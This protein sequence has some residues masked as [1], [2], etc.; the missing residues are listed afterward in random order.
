MERIRNS[1]EAW[2]FHIQ[3][4]GALREIC[5]KRKKSE[6]AK[7]NSDVRWTRNL[8]RWRVKDSF[9]KNYLSKE[10]TTPRRIREVLI[11]LCLEHKVVTRDDIKRELVQKG[12]ATDEGQVGRIL[13]TISREI[14]I[15]KRIYLRQ[16]I[17]YD[18]QNWEKEN[19]RVE[20][21]YRSMI[22]EWLDTLG[23]RA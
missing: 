10:R 20:E 17:C 1:S 21:R 6:K 5:W 23:G 2:Y 16:I 13:T 4:W 22:N 11:P 18:K 8:W 15:E 3:I 9:K 19:F 7:K 12:E 14:G